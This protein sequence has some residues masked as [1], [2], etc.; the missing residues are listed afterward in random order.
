MTASKPEV[1]K[2]LYYA[3]TMCCPF[4][5]GQPFMCR[6]VAEVEPPPDAI[7]KVHCPWDNMPLSVRFRY[8]KPVKPFPPTRWVLRYSPPQESSES[9]APPKRRWWQF[10]K[11]K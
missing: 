11:R 5:P 4:C 1:R 2:R 7:I 10:W 6:L 9:P 8:F 3:F